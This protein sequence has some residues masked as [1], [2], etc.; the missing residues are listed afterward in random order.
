MTSP[1]ID[2]TTFETTV[3][4]WSDDVLLNPFP[5]Y[6]QLR[7]IGPAAYMTKYGFWFIGRYD[8]VKNAL[9]DW[10]TFSSAHMGGI[11]LNAFTN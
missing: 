2:L 4:L 7:D 3:D 5:A 6:K 8:I 1:T 10:E 11:A 9:S